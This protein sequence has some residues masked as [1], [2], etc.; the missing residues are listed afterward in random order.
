MCFMFF[1]DQL[2]LELPCIGEL[3]HGE[4][5]NEMPCQQGKD[6]AVVDQLSTQVGQRFV[7]SQVSR[8]NLCGQAI[9]KVKVG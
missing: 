4:N 8:R 1:D 7:N 3:I 6:N 5:R 9:W 2:S